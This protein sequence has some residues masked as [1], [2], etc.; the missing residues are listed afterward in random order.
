MQAVNRR[1]LVVVDHG[2]RVDAANQLLER[3]V[4][5]LRARND[6]GYVAV[7]AAHMELAAPS[8]PDAFARCVKA[9]AAHIVVVQFFLSPGRHASE[10]IPR[11][12]AAAAEV[13]GGVSWSVSEPIGSDSRLIDVILARA[14]ATG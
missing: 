13:C 8:I 10:D 7:E 1:A 14:D 5:D 2:S 11:M 3:L 6:R 9:G 4:D 12:V